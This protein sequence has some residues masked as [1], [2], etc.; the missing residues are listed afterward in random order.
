MAVAAKTGRAHAAHAA[1]LLATIPGLKIC[2]AKEAFWNEFS[3]ILPDSAASVIGKGRDAGLHVGVDITGRTPCGCNLLKISFSD[4]QSDAD[5]AKLVAFF[6]GLYGRHTGHG[7]IAEVPAALRRHDAVG[8]P[9]FTVA[10]LKEY[11][12]KLGELNVSRTPDA[13]RSA[14]AR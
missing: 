8:L 11:Y 4:L 3:L 2:Y 1:S 12:T 7:L 14:P 6:E 5:V 10:E 9:S 13:S